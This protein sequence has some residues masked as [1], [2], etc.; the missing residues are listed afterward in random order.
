MKKALTLGVLALDIL[1]TGWAIGTS[2]MG[3]YL[4]T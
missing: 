2:V 1:K 3:S 4:L